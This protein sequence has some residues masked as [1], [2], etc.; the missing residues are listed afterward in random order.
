MAGEPED[1]SAPKGG[2][3]ERL[4]AELSEPTPSVVPSG[5]KLPAPLAPESEPDA[6]AF[7]AA[8][9]AAAGA[10]QGAGQVLAS[11][12]RSEKL[13]NMMHHPL[14]VSLDHLERRR[15]K[16]WQSGMG[17]DREQVAT[18]LVAALAAERIHVEFDSVDW[19]GRAEI[20]NAALKHVEAVREI[21]DV[22][23]GSP[24][25]EGGQSRVRALRAKPGA[26]WADGRFWWPGG[27]I[28]RP[29]RIVGW[30]GAGERHMTAL[31]AKKHDATGRS[32]GRRKTNARTQIGGQFAP[33]LIEM[34]RSPALRVLSLSERRCLDRLEIELADHG[35]AD[36]GKLPCRYD[37]FEAY[38]VHRHSIAP[39]LRAL[40]ALGFI[41]VTREGRAGNAEWRR[42]TL[43][44]LTYRPNATTGATDE[45][46][47]IEALEQAETIA[48]VARQAS[49]K[50]NPRVGKRTMHRCENRTTRD[51]IHSAD[52]ATTLPH[53][54][55]QRLRL[56]LA[57]GALAPVRAAGMRRHRD[58]HYGLE[59]SRR[60]RLR[61]HARSH[62]PHL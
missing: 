55:L 6:T 9:R 43:F 23:L 60:P 26:P 28:Y 59:L 11:G 56:L 37:D 24:P 45:W 12:F 22:V 21:A 18:G 49:K 13:Q 29:S 33:R 2:Q 25:S 10:I 44:R 4:A 16:V 61:R 40:A 36:N 8:F 14:R 50:Q 48:R 38:G 41:E 17:R 46:R 19:A 51:E 27:A 30:S 15:A 57:M 3:S 5:T 52:S 35:G 39:S 7:V 20:V 62:A 42:P 32:V 54:N 58:L 1:G 47:R 31:G 34:L 53:N